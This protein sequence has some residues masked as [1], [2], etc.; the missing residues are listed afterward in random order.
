MIVR[1]AVP[2]IYSYR[3]CW[4][5]SWRLDRLDRSIAMTAGLF[6]IGTSLTIARTRPLS[7]QRTRDANS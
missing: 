1:G 6:K 5:E 4:W 3:P 7:F 2:A